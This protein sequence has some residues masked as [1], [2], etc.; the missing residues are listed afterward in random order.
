M[1]PL[2]AVGISGIHAGEDVNAG[3]HHLLKELLHARH[4]SVA[5]DQ[6]RRVAAELCLSTRTLKR[7]RAEVRRDEQASSPIHRTPMPSMIRP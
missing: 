3:R 6:G 7:I 4:I 1:P 5:Q 2:S